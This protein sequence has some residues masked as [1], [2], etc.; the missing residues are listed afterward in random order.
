MRPKPGPIVDHT[1]GKV[2][3]KHDGLWNYTVGQNAK[4]AGMSFQMFVAKKDPEKNEVHIVPGSYALLN[5]PIFIQFNH[6][7]ENMQ[8]CNQELWFV[9]SGIGSGLMPLIPFH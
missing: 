3:G 9:K 4:L 2:V 5:Q 8:L 7:I 6:P 1:T